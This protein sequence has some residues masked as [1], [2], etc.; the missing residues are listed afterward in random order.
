VSESYIQLPPDGTGKKTRA[1]KRTVNGNEVYEEANVIVDP[2]TGDPL[3]PATDD[4]LSTFSD[5]FP[6]AQALS[7]TLPNPTA[8]VIASALLGWYPSGNVWKRLQVDDGGAL[9]VRVV[10]CIH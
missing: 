7:D 3:K 8:T 9:K 1:L 6:S 10:G 2:V 4:T 5:K